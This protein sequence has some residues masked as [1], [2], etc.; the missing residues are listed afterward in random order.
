MKAVQN[1]LT[2]SSKLS[3]S[4]FYYWLIAPLVFLTC[5]FL[6]T[7]SGSNSFRDMLQEPTV[8]LSFMA[9][10]MSL[11]LAG[12]LKLAQRTGP[13]SLKT[14]CL[15]ASLQQL[16][17]GN[18]IGLVLSFC[19]FWSLCGQ[20]WPRQKNPLLLLGMVFITCLSLLISLLSINYYL[21]LS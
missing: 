13:H 9:A 19:L 17:V 6:L 16:L 4:L 12:L 8:T 20:A 14:F 5:V 15:V 7:N 10:C 1:F 21:H 2:D 3:A 18:L 11:I